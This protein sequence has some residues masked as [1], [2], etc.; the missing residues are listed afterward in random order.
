[1]TGYGSDFTQHQRSRLYAHDH[2]PSFPPAPPGAI[3]GGANS[4]PHP[5]FYA[6]PRLVGLPP[7]C[8]YLDEPTSEVTN[9]VCVRWNAPLVWLAVYL[10]HAAPGA[11]APS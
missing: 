3:A 6:D 8:C 2:D 9:D 1:M 7:Q 10:D 11:Q 4:R 5:G